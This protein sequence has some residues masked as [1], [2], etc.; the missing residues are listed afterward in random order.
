MEERV[1]GGVVEDM[2]GEQTGSAKI[3]FS[4]MSSTS[5][6]AEWNVVC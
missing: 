6:Y 1:R 4:Q 5:W 2:R 3:Q